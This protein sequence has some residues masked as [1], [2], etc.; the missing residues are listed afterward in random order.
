[1][2][3]YNKKRCKI[4]TIELKEKRRRFNKPIIRKQLETYRIKLRDFVKPSEIINIFFSY[5][6][7]F[8]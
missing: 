6:I 1:M 3:F 5:L 7:L 4:R 2:V 8:D